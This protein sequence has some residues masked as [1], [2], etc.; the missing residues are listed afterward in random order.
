MDVDADP[1]A[2]D[3]VPPQVE[4]ARA[5]DV[6]AGQAVVVDLVAG[7][8]DV[9]GALEH[10]DAAALVVVGAVAP[11]GGVRAADGQDHAVLAVVAEDVVL[12][13]EV[14]AA[15]VGVEAVA[16][17]PLD[18]RVGHPHGR[19]VV[20]VY[21]VPVA[22]EGGVVD[23]AAGGPGAPG[24]AV[25]LGPVVAEHLHAGVDHGH[26]RA[27]PG[28]HPGAAVVDAAVGPAGGPDPGGDGAVRDLEPAAVGL[29]A[30]EAPRLRQQAQVGP[31]DL[32][33]GAAPDGEVAGQQPAAVLADEDVGPPVPGQ[34]P[35]Q[36]GQVDA[37]GQQLQ[38]LAAPDRADGVA[39]GLGRGPGEDEPG[40]RPEGG[41]DD[42][43]QPR[44]ERPAPAV[45]T[46]SR[47]PGAPPVGF[48]R[49]GCGTGGPGGAGW[50]RPGR[51]RR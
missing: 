49:S 10:D 15:G 3:D 29:Q 17:G 13:V 41:G 14:A 38:A 44:G 18:H 6:D 20:E 12:D 19:D 27:V 35:G 32:Q 25:A 40:R 8:G 11:D 16:V 23:G 2:V 50:P 24:D 43:D 45:P 48:A 46:T 28:Q 30:D 9:V 31:V 21:A 42:Q 4:P 33:A 5:V 22:A 26:H 37:A 39:P 7:E 51:P 36:R 34:G 47:H 1:V